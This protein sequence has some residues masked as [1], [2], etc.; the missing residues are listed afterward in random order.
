MKEKRPPRKT[1]ARKRNVESVTEQKDRTLTD[2]AKAGMSN[3]MLTGVGKQTLTGVSNP[4]GE[5][6][7]RTEGGSEHITDPGKQIPMQESQ[8]SV[9][10]LHI[11]G[12]GIANGTKGHQNG[13]T[14]L[15]QR[16]ADMT[17]GQRKVKLK[18]PKLIYRSTITPQIKGGQMDKMHS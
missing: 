11:E 5:K 6:R 17:P 12:I 4:K 3:D 2:S 8:N 9:F 16:Q 18:Q 10:S 1:K 7:A 13:E 15:E 14:D